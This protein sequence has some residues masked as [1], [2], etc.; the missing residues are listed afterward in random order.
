MQGDVGHR[1]HAFVEGQ[2]ADALAD[3]VPCLC[4]PD[5]D[6]D[7]GPDGDAPDDFA[8]GWWS[9]WCAAVEMLAERPAPAR[10]IRTSDVLSDADT[11]YWR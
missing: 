5:G 6:C 9:G 3:A 11:A 10:A 7:H 8:R 4:G 1:R 2:H